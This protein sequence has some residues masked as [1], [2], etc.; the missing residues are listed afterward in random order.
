MRIKTFTFSVFILVSISL[1]G[2]Q[3]QEAVTTGGGE[4]S[5]SGGSVSY[6]AGQVTYTIHST[7]SGSLSQGVQQ[8][9][10]I[11]V[12]VGIEDSAGINLFCTSYPNP[13]MDILIL[14]I[15]DFKNQSLAYQLY[16]VEGY[17]IGSNEI[18]GS[19]T[20]ISMGNLA[21]GTYFLKILDN[22]SFRLI[23]TFKIIK[24]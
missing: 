14:E 11:Y 2:L 21:L 24:H 3:A 5:G 22:T 9:Y 17:L 18:K 20:T 15:R 4:A 16:N 8:P 23:K 6:T 1:S 7:G 12:E 19:V 10:E 13:V